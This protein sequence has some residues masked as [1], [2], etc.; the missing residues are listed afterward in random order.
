MSSTLACA[1]KWAVFVNS[2]GSNLKQF[3]LASGTYCFVDNF[4]KL[5]DYRTNWLNNMG[6]RGVQKIN[7]WGPSGGPFVLV[8]GVVF[9]HGNIRSVCHMPNSRK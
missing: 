9:S 2:M 1:F 7:N 4:L 5:I 3:E 6:G 8:I